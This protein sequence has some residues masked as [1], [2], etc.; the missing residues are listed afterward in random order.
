MRGRVGYFDIISICVP[1]FTAIMDKG[2]QYYLCSI[3]ILAN[4]PKTI[5]IARF[6]NHYAY[7]AKN[8]NS[9]YFIGKRYSQQY[10]QLRSLSIQHTITPPRFCNDGTLPGPFNSSP[11]PVN[12]PPSAH[13]PKPLYSLPLTHAHESRQSIFPV[14]CFPFRYTIRWS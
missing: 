3:A 14:H 1:S 13:I 4:S 10:F 12:Y 8:C 11:N 7:P 2:C 9:E 5:H 6:V